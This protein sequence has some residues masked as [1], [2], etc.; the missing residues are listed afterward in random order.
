MADQG[1]KDAVRKETEYFSALTKLAESQDGQVLITALSKQIAADLDSV[2]SNYK[3]ASDISI[4]A[5]LAKIDSNLVIMRALGR[6]RE[7]FEAS[8][9]YLRELIG[10]SE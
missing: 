2:L 5:N 8:D 4:R 3:T 7:N 6:A 1:T 10:V 9:E